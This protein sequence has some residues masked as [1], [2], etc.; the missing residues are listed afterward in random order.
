MTE[1]SPPPAD[2]E[3]TDS[4]WKAVGHQDAATANHPP[5]PKAVKVG[6]L[7][8][9]V[10]VL[11]T[12]VLVGLRLGGALEPEPE[13]SPTPKL[14]MEPPVQLGS[15]VRGALNTSDDG[16]LVSADYTD[17]TA[18]I[19]LLLQ[20][21]QD[22]LGAFMLDAGFR[23]SAPSSSATPS[24]TGTPSAMLT[25]SVSSSPSASGSPSP[26]GTEATGVALCGYSPE[27][28]DEETIGCAT[29][30]QDTGLMVVGL[31]NQAEEEIRG[32]LEDFEQAVTP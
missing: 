4:D 16:N 8:L 3:N 1:Q 6:G 10:V 23:D 25:P 11:V 24:V 30:T 14:T 32:L 22:D 19:V 21:P 31:S 2:E 17:G 28:S 18:S 12:A 29:V 5:L 7:A 27:F 15:Y 9:L 13:P 26:S 20:W